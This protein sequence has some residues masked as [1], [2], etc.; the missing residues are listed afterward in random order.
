[1]TD[2]QTMIN[3]FLQRQKDL[4]EI[5]QRQKNRTFHSHLNP[6]LFSKNSILRKEEDLRED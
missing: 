6:L 1:M 5:Q 2:R 4:A 3:T